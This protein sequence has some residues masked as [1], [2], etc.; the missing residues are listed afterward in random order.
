MMDISIELDKNDDLNNNL[1]DINEFDVPSFSIEI[2]N[3][4]K[5]LYNKFNKNNITLFDNSDY[6]KLY[7]TFFSSE[8]D[9][10]NINFIEKEN[11]YNIVIDENEENSFNQNKFHLNK[12]ENNNIVNNKKQK[13]KKKTF[14]NIVNNY[15][16]FVQKDDFIK[17][18]S[19]KRVRN[20]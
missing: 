6:K 14:L 10:L 1:I 2:F 12:K 16:K 8:N 5:I 13:E 4:N 18:I 7:S 11:N 20:N 9:L 17:L 15:S 3:K 19:S